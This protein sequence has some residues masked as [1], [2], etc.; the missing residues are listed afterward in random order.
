MKPLPP[1]RH[2]APLLLLL[3]VFSSLHRPTAAHPWAMMIEDAAKNAGI[4]DQAGGENGG[5]GYEQEQRDP[6]QQ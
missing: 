4:I 6:F 5:I 1:L 3:S 2:A